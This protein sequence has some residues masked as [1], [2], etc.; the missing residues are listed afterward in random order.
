MKKILAGLLLGL[1]LA[2]DA[3]IQAARTFSADASHFV[4]YAAYTTNHTSTTWSIWVYR[5]GAGGTGFG[6]IW[7]KGSTSI[8]GR[9]F[10]NGAN[11]DFDRESSTTDGHWAMTRPS[12]SVWHNIVIT[13]DSS[14]LAND[15]IFYVDGSSVSPVAGEANPT[16]TISNN[17]QGYEVG[18]F[19]NGGSPTQNFG[20]SLAEFAVWDVILSAGEIL[21]V[22]RG[23]SPL[24]IRYANL[25]LYAPLSGLHAWEPD[26]GSTKAA[27]DVNGATATAHH[28]PVQSIFWN[29]GAQNNDVSAGGVAP[30]I[31]LQRRRR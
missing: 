12:D 27:G 23:T 24:D 21:S 20:G 26:F 25:K 19:H 13:Y 3:V 5:T 14:A 28:P 10:N 16:G 7:F 18:N 29:Y 31:Y 17:S 6:R 8:D 1:L 15:P 30:F 2:H 22:A 4:Q 11:Y 9:F